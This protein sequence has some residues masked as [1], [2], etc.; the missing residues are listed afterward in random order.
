MN[1]RDFIK[2]TMQTTAAIAGAAALSP[3]AFAAKNREKQK[4]K[5]LVLRAVPVKTEIP[6]RWRTALSKARSTEHLLSNRLTNWGKA[7]EI[8]IYAGCGVV[9]R[10]EFCE[11]GGTD[12][13]QNRQSVQ[14]TV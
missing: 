11:R 4:M 8:E 7:Y 12:E 5:I 3:V 9:R 13:Q 14:R 2:K 6:T 10:G 1:R